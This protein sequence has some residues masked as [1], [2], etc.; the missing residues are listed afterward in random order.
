MDFDS[1]GKVT[2]DQFNEDVKKY[3]KKSIH[4]LEEE[5]RLINLDE[6]MEEPVY[7]SGGGAKLNSTSGGGGVSHHKEL[8]YQRRIAS[9]EDKVKQA[10]I[11]LRNESSLRNQVEESLR[12]TERHHD[13][14]REQFD[15]T[16]D[17]YFKC[18]QKIKEQKALLDQS[19]LA[20]D[21]T[22]FRK[23][24]IGLRNQ[25]EETRSAL[26]SYKNMQNVT[27][28][29]VKSLKLLHERKKDEHKT[30]EATLRDIESQNFDHQQISKLHYVVMLS[31]WQEAA[32]NKKYEMKH[33]ECKELRS[34]IQ[35]IQDLNEE[36]E[37]EVAEAEASRAKMS[38]QML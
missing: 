8:E 19:I 24:N 3:L 14:L 35:A 38:Q 10:Y 15:T 29:Q 2:W 12:R 26:I 30:L 37:L 33:N 34:E 22:N 36:K 32:V 9:L 28:E 4:E 6:Q 21:A 23:E 20:D 31:R 7:T 5:E 17:E 18:Q 13:A 25:L 11:H 27:T 1:R 16:R